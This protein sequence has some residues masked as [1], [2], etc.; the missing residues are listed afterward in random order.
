MSSLSLLRFIAVLCFLGALWFTMTAAVMS[1]G[2][3][4]RFIAGF[5]GL[6]FASF[7]GA[8]LALR[9]GASTG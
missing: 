4:L 9:H 8:L 5:I 1:G 2:M 3:A 7:G 6:L